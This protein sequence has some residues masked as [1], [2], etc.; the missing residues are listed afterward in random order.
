MSPQ[1]ATVNQP[2]R[3]PLV[4]PPEWRD[5]TL[6]KDAR[7]INCIAEFVPQR[8]RYDVKKRPGIGPNT[9][10]HGGTGPFG[11]FAAGS[12][13]FYSTGGVFY[14]AES[15]LS[16]PVSSA[17]T[18]IYILGLGS[19]GVAFV[20][21]D[22]GASI[23]TH[24]LAWQS[25]PITDPNYPPGALPGAAWLDGTFYVM[26]RN[27]VIY[28][29]NFEDPT[30]WNSTNTIAAQN[31]PDAGVALVKHLIYVLALKQWTVEVFYDAGNATGSPLSP[32]PE[33][34]MTYGCANPYT[35]QDMDGTKFWLTST[36]QGQPQLLRL[37]GLTPS[38]VSTPPVDRALW[39]FLPSPNN[40]GA[41]TYSTYSFVLKVGGHRYYG[42]TSVPNNLT[43]AYDMDQQ[44]WYQWT[45]SNGNYWPIAYGGFLTA[46]VGGT[47]M[48]TQI[49]QNINT[50]RLVA[51]D[52]DYVYPT[53]AGTVYTAD[54]YT[55]RFDLNI[56]RVKQHG[57]LHLNSDFRESPVM[58]R[59]TDEDYVNW[60]NPQYIAMDNMR[61]Y[62]S[63]L[64]SFYRRAFHFRIQD[65]EPLRMPE[66]D[67]QLDVGPA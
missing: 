65:D 3:I 50:G 31:E 36:R 11:M 53:D 18:E 61:P 14:A 21:N 47:V 24:P 41:N 59:Y 51:I 26:N 66:M 46:N 45:D 64:G 37:D 48:T 29:S 7:L 30:T 63:N 8:K 52:A 33:A 62:L 39:A 1:V 16:I 42:L 67:L 56:D 57:G 23:I 10:A 34:L 22:V 40:S 12:T 4:S 58:V 54:I 43:L 28:G 44:L 49:A 19:T 38:I 13:T 60:S 17:P 25:T 20:K 5:T 55:E 9:S 6:T 27:G 2:A 35:I 15:P 32:V